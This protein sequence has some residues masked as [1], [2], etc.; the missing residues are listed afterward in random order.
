MFEQSTL[1]KTPR[2][3]WATCLGF[4][5][6]AVLVTSLV[7]CPLIWPQVI[8]RVAYYTTLATPGPPPGPPPKGNSVQRQHRG[9][10]THILNTSAFTEPA[11]VPQHAISIVDP[12]PALGDFGVTNGSD[13]GVP[14]GI[15][16]MIAT[17]GP[18]LR[19]PVVARPPEPVRPPAAPSAPA[20]IQRYRVGGKVQLAEPV[21]R[22][23]PVYPPLARS[24]RIGGVV[25]L[26]AVIGTD[27]RVKDL[28]L[29]SGHPLLARAAL[30][31]V[32]RWIYRPTTLND[33]PIE[34]EAPITVT[35][36]LSN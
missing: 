24:M 32:S 31:A 23:E 7:L 36:R 27:G 13:T 2:R 33:T 9:P 8:P 6:E 11:R 15:P 5:A 16:G 34:V 19:P 18:E 28:R 30:D 1:P 35:F 3:L 14:G 25:E 22:P 20:S 29:K 10:S 17:L 21:F 12:P 4:S 26:I